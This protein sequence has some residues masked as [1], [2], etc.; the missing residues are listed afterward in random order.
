MLNTPLVT[1]IAA[2]PTAA[3]NAPSAYVYVSVKTSVSVESLILT[4][5]SAMS[6]SRPES[7]KSVVL[8]SGPPM[9]LPSP[10]ITS[11]AP[12]GSASRSDG[13]MTI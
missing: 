7:V 1:S 2:V 12:T 13:S 5:I 3:V 10:T 4:T 9:L 8:T 6:E 11:S